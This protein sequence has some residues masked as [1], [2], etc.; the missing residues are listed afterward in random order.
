M[1]YQRAIFPVSRTPLLGA[2]LFASPHPLPLLIP[3][4]SLS[5]N[6]FSMLALSF[7]CTPNRLGRPRNDDGRLWRGGLLHVRTGRTS[8]RADRGQ[9][10]TDPAQ[11]GTTQRSGR[12]GR[13]RRG[14]RVDGWEIGRTDG[15]R[16]RAERGMRAF[17]DAER[18]HS[19]S[20][21]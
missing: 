3:S 8:S 13:V 12:I 1:V 16:W 15:R 2:M 10:G 18:K 7:V 14:R 11:Q 9:E 20:Q 6:V 21:A 17:V 19:T 5:R 4:R